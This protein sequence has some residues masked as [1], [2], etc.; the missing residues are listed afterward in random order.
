VEP[1]RLRVLSPRIKLTIPKSAPDTQKVAKPFTLKDT[2][3]QLRTVLATIESRMPGLE[4]DVDD[5]HVELVLPSQP[6]LI[7]ENVNLVVD[8]DPASVLVSGGV[9]TSW[10]K[11][12]IVRVLLSPADESGLVNVDIDQLDAAALGPAFALGD[13]WPVRTAVVN[14]TVTVNLHGLSDAQATITTKSPAVALQFGKARIDARSLA[15]DAT[16]QTAHGAVTLALKELALDAPRIGASGTLTRDSVG[17]FSVSV[18]LADLDLPTAQTLIQGLAPAVPA[19]RGLP[20]NVTRGTLAGAKLESRASNISD[21]FG[22]P[23]MAITARLENTDATLTVF[24]DLPITNASAAVSLSGGRLHV[25][26]LAASV[27]PTSARDGTFDIDL[28]P[29]V[30][31][32]RGTVTVEADLAQGFAIAGRVLG[33]DSAATLGPITGVHGSVL[34]RATITGNTDSVVPRV[35]FSQLHAFAHYAAIPFPV[36]II[37]G[38]GTY[39]PAAL[40]VRG[41]RGTIGHSTFDSLDAA[42]ALAGPMV[43]T[44]SRGSVHL[45]LPELFHWASQQPKLAKQLDSVRSVSGALTISV[46]ALSLPVKTPDKLTFSAAAFPSHI[47]VDAPHYGPRATVDG[48]V[49]H[50]TEKRVNASGV[51]ASA[52]D[53]HLVVAGGT[54]DYRDSTSEILA[55]AKGTVGLDALAWVYAKA[56]LPD[57]LKLRG[58]L[59][60]NDASV[61]LRTSAGIGAN[62]TLVVAGGPEIGFDL[63]SRTERL[64]VDQFTLKDAASN[65]SAG[66][67][68]DGA[69]IKALWKG[70]LA[71][72]TLDHIFVHSPLE[73]DYIDGDLR[74]DGDLKKPETS[75]ATGTLSGSK[76]DLERA[77]KAPVVIDRLSLE[78]KDSVFYVRTLD[79]SSGASR[80][81]VTGSIAFRDQKFIVDATLRAD[82]LIIPVHVHHADT[83]A[84]PV[85][86]PA[87]AAPAPTNAEKETKFIKALRE[88]PARGTARVDIGYLKVGR[89]EFSPLQ[90]SGSIT[91]PRID[92]AVTH[93]AL[94]GIALSGGLV[95]EHDTLDV[96]AG[97][98]AN[99][100]PLAHAIACLSDQRVDITGNVTVDG[101]FSSHAVPGAVVDNLRGTFVLTAKDG[102]INKFDEFAKILK[103]A[104]VTQVLVGQ[105]SDLKQGGMA[106]KTFTTDMVITGPRVEMK[107]MTLDASGLDA[108]AHGTIDFDRET[109]DIDVLVAPVKTLNWIVSHTPIV[110]SIFGGSIL[111][112][113]VHVGGTISHPV[114]V[115]L[116]AQAV[117][118][119]LFDILGN[120]VKL[121]A[122]MIKTAPKA[123]TATKPE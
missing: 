9:T 48:G 67:S 44:A 95:V 38:G 62:G 11:R 49:V 116:G 123:D 86:V 40:S 79:V 16:A 47:A 89:I 35:D 52:L 66:A 115:P 17:A 33:K 114:V 91:G 81:S 7:L 59:T 21:L 102:R 94:C 64:Q 72:S 61:S 8:V 26:S 97:L 76:I 22:L 96:T 1:R 68:I 69:R 65:L 54:E 83:G 30:P 6:P 88:I 103:V 24:Q 113:P 70:R 45:A 120:T 121:P 108:G 111:A 53:A 63:H 93:A 51:S 112:I 71:G 58:G 75:R 46:A 119:R 105:S 10:A 92:L 107:S 31:P 56:K 50:V 84:K 2:D 73:L 82:T 87:N 19:L 85:A 101:K 60:I 28:N 99:N 110:R 25:A 57:A 14:A 23:A 27:G 122:E 106:Y 12:V 104:N 100:A 118:S 80:G 5:G 77:I 36:R 37:D 74:I 41:L 78:A 42:L 117:S 4:A 15:L 3:A 32:M 34:A 20:V 18:Q 39:S 55:F 43:V 109:L 13:D 98:S 90:A 29:A